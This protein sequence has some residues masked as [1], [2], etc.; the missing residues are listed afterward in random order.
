[1]WSVCFFVLFV[2]F[3]TACQGYAMASWDTSLIFFCN[4]A[5]NTLEYQI[6]FLFEMPLIHPP[7]P[8]KNMV[9]MCFFFFNSIYKWAGSFA[10]LKIQMWPTYDMDSSLL[11]I[12][13]HASVLCMWHFA[14]MCPL[15]DDGKRPPKV[16]T[17]GDFLSQGP[18][19]ERSRGKGRG[20]KPSYR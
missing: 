18:R 1:M 7:T 6:M 10:H 20:G 4:S 12:K 15:A 2:F 8:K 9:V 11:S 14:T 5:C 3:S 13:L 16:S 19:G 17:F